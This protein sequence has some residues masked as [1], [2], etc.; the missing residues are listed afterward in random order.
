MAVSGHLHTFAN[1][2]SGKVPALATEQETGRVSEL[3]SAL[4]CFGEEKNLLI[5]LQ[6]HSFLAVVSHY[7][8]CPV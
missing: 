3:Y 8:Q 1:L 2:F 6:F 4:G 7:P 5:T